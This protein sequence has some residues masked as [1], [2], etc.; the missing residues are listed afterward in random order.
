ME[1]LVKVAVPVVAVK[2]PVTTSA[3][4]KEKLLVVV[5]D[6]L[7]VSDEKLMFP[8]PDNVLA[9]PLMVMVPAV[10]DNV[11]PVPT[12]KLSDTFRLVAVA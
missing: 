8:A 7:M 5:T 4:D 11:A 6:P 2:L 10:A 12:E 1:L 3:S 9:A